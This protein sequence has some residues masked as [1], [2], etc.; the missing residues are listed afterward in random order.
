MIIGLLWNYTLG[1][2]SHICAQYF[3][4]VYFCLSHENPVLCFHFVV[5]GV[6]CFHILLSFVSSE[7]LWYWHPPFS[8]FALY[9]NLTLA[10][11]CSQSPC[12]TAHVSSVL[13]HPVLPCLFLF[14]AHKRTCISLRVVRTAVF[15]PGFLFSWSLYPACICCV[16]AFLGYPCWVL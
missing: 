12:S 3:F 10:I 16:N 2:F 6:R 7:T 14:L 13:S 5:Y 9:L 11:G 1:R 4:T 8:C 15:C